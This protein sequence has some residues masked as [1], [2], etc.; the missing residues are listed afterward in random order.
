MAEERGRRYPT[1]VRV[2]LIGLQAV[3][4][5]VGIVVGTATYDAWSQ[6]DDGGSPTTTTVVPEVP[7]T[8][9]PLG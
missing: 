7:V 5:V 4:I 6:P 8:E 1:W 9:A 3:G 2:V